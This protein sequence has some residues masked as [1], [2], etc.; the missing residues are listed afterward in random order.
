MTDFAADFLEA[1]RY[2]HWMRFYF[3]EDADAAGESPDS[4]DGEGEDAVLAVPSGFREISRLQ[5]PRLF[6][7]L[8]G[9][10][11]VPVSMEASRDV[12]FAWLGGMHGMEPGGE[13]FESAM[14]ALAGDTG[15]MKRLD[16]FHGWVQ[17]LADGTIDLQGNALPPSAP[18]DDRVVSF[19][20][21]EKAFGFWESIQKP[22]GLPA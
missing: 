19:A 6:P 17:N 20:E 1:M 7:I 10:D 9:L 13:D 12:I 15:F 8:E 22:V 3:A 2:E 16:M 21:W 4:G 5:E 14:A 11:G 18:P